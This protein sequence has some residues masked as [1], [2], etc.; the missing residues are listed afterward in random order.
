MSASFFLNIKR[1]LFMQE[2]AIASSPYSLGLLH[3]IWI[4]FTI[5]II[6]YTYRWCKRKIF[7]R[8]GKEREGGG[9]PLTNNNRKTRK[10]RYFV[11]QP[12]SFCLGHLAHSRSKTINILHLALQMLLNEGSFRGTIDWLVITYW[13]LPL[14]KS[15]YTLQLL[16]KLPFFVSWN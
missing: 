9:V 3:N 14:V 11:L 2:A 6:S 15:E 1:Q 16:L 7:L 13:D 5:L 10:N 12:H 8:I 4:A